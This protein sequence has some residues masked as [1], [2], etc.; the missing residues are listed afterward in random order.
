MTPGLSCGLVQSKN[1]L[2]TVMQSMA[3]LCWLHLFGTVDSL[4]LGK[5]VYGLVA[6]EYTFLNH[7]GFATQEDIS[8][9]I[10]L[11]LFMLFK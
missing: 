5:V 1:A 8:P 3:A 7:V 4:V 2:N 6:E 10:P 11:A 9:H